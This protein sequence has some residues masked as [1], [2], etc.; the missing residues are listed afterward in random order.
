MKSFLR[1]LGIVLCAQLFHDPPDVIPR[2]ALAKE[3]L[4]PVGLIVPH[5]AHELADL[6]AQ[7]V[8]HLAVASAGRDEVVAQYY[9]PG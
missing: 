2:L 6:E 4:L 8:L 1:R 5:Q 7:G 9:A 3:L